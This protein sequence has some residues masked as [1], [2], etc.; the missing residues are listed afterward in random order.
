MWSRVFYVVRMDTGQNLPT[1]IMRSLF[2]SKNL[3]AF[4]G[5]HHNAADSVPLI[6]KI[7]SA[8]FTESRYHG[9]L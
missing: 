5:E 8:L 9:R 6:G 4:F 3:I 2:N 7:I 1:G